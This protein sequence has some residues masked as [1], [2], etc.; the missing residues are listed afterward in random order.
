MTPKQRLRSQELSVGMVL[1]LLV[2]FQ[3]EE[4]D[5]GSGRMGHTQDMLGT[6]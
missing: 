5:S 2:Q 4:P 6:Q 3:V 1:P